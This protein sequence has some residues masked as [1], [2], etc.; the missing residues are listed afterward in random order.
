M[1]AHAST[2]ADYRYMYGNNID[3][4][5]VLLDALHDKTE[6]EQRVYIQS[7]IDKR[8]LMDTNMM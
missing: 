5:Q 1:D 8:S 6:A 4:Y 7:L 3:I 2:F